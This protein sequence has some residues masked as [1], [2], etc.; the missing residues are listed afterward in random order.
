MIVSGVILTGGA[1][2]LSVCRA[3][4]VEGFEILEE[5]EPGI[6]LLR[7]DGG[8]RA[9]TKAGGFGEKDALIN[10]VKYLRRTTAR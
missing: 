6:P 4:E 3:L 1:T 10:I 7:L 5:V 8:L 2:A 9:V